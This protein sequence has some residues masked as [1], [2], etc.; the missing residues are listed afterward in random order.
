MEKLIAQG[1]EAKLFLDEITGKTV[2]VKERFKKNY[3]HPDLNKKLNDERTKAEVR[4]ILKC[5]E[6]GSLNLF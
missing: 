5:K 3:R 2:L 4:C 1:A 6:N